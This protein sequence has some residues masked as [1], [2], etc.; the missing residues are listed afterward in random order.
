[1]EIFANPEI[2]PF[3][4]LHQLFRLAAPLAPRYPSVFQ[5]NVL[6]PA[7]S[8]PLVSVMYFAQTIVPTF[9]GD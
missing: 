9:E 6:K 4:R 5:A 3:Y 8:T 2:N 7:I 1:M